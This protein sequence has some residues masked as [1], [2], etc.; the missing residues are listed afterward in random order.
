MNSLMTFLIILMMNS[1]TEDTNL[2]LRFGFHNM[3]S[4]CYDYQ[5]VFEHVNAVF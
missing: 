3:L 2:T 5:D 4:N 1:V